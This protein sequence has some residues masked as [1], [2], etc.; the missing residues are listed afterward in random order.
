ML[1]R[2]SEFHS[3]FDDKTLRSTSLVSP[4]TKHVGEIRGASRLPMPNAALLRNQPTSISSDFSPQQ[5]NNSNFKEARQ[6]SPL[7]DECPMAFE[8][9]LY[10]LNYSLPEYDHSWHRK[11][12]HFIEITCQISSNTEK[13]RIQRLTCFGSYNFPEDRVS[14]LCYDKIGI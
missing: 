12:D 2:W 9:L 4:S 6:T 3:H 10:C 1:H 8:R 5:R 14:F 13:W 11:Q 7:K